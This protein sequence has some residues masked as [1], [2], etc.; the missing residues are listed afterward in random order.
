MNTYVVND[1]VTNQL[2]W[3]EEAAQALINVRDFFVTV[4]N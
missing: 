4:K 1:E 2:W 3:S